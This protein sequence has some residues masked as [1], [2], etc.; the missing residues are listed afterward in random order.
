MISEKPEKNFSQFINKYS[1][2]KTLRFELRPIGNT[3]RMLI[4]SGVVEIDKQRKEA[5]I[6]TKPFFDK[7]HQEFITESL[8]GVKLLTLEG[9]FDLFDNWRK[10]KDKNEK[11]KTLEKLEKKEKEIRNEIVK[12]FDKKSADW[13]EN[14]PQDLKPKKINHEF[15]FEKGI[16][17]IAKEKYKEDDEILTEDG[18][19]IFD[20]WDKWGAYFGK[21]F[22]TRKNFYK[23]DGTATAVATRV[24]NDNLRRFCENLSLFERIVKIVNLSSIE[25]D[26]KIDL[27]EFFSFSQYNNILNQ[28]GI[29][30][31]NSLIGGET[32]E[33]GKKIKGINEL[34][35]EFRQKTKEKIPRLK[36]LDKQIGSER[37]IF[38]DTIESDEDLLTRLSEFVETAIEKNKILDESIDYLL[39]GEG[40][41]SKIYFRKEALNT[42]TRRWFVSYEKIAEALVLVI[43][44]KNVKFDKTK[45]EYK[46]PDFVNWQVIKEAVE[47]I[48]TNEE[49]VIWKSYYTENEQL[50]LNSKNHWQQFL[51]IFEF[52]YKNLKESGHEKDGESF[53]ELSLKLKEMLK[54]GKRE[55]E[56]IKRFS[57]R[58]LNLYRFAKYFSL[59]KSR[60]WN[61][62]GLETDDFYVKYEE[63]YSDSF[64][65]TVKTYDKIRNYMTKKPFNQEKWKLNFDNPTLADGWDKNKETD[66]TAVIL[67]KNGRYYLG[68]MEKKNN[69][70]FDKLESRQEEGGYEKMVYKLFPDPAK[71]MPKV[72]FSKK[73]IETF[74][75]SEEILRIYK[76]SE[77]KKGE[78]FSIDSM[79]KLIDFYKRALEKYEG[80]TLYD[81]KNVKNTNEYTENIGQFYRDVAEDGYFIVFENISEEYIE[82]ANQ[83]GKLYLFEI[84]NK[85]WNLKDGA[86]KTGT[87]NIHTLYFEQVFS[88]ENADNNF[89]IKLNGEA[90]LFFRSK[91]DKKDLGEKLIKGEKRINHFR[92]SKD[93]MFFHVPI[94]LNRTAPEAKK[95]NQ[96]I[97]EFL[98][99]NKNINIIGIDR[100]EKHLAY[101]SVINQKGE[102][103]EIK[104][105]NKITIRDDKNEVVREIDYASL[106]E[107]RAK[108]REQARK[109]WQSVEQIKDLKKGYIS[110]V[111]REVADLIIKYNAIVVFEDL[112]MRFKQV[113]GGIEKSVYQQLEKALIDKLNYLVSKEEIDSKKAGHILHAYQLT[114]K[115]DSFQKMGKQTGVLFYTQAEYTSQT[116]PV[117]GFRKNLYISNS[118]VIEK[119]K[120]FIKNFKAIGFD[121]ELQSYFF[122][123]NA[124]DFIVD[125][126]IKKTSYEKE[127]TVYA[128]VPRI[129]REKQASGHWETKIVNPNDEFKNLFEKWEFENI[130]AEDI[131]DLIFQMESDKRL[132]GTREFD[133]RKR[134]FWQSF[135]YLFNLV[136]Q[137]RN[138]T[139]TQFKKDEEGK[140]IEVVEGVDFIS[141]PVKPF[142]CT[143]A[144]KFTKG[145]TNMAG[146]ESKFIGDKDLKDKFVEEFNGD[147]NGAYNIARK[148]IIILNR[149]NEYYSLPEEKRPKYPDIFISRDDWDR[150]SQ[151]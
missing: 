19:T 4:D 100:G 81:F 116:D 9:Y 68:I 38:I 141:S 31:Y 114:E 118:S 24:V 1:L 20:S 102:I 46:F 94:T 22:E 14:L 44:D 17:A 88:K 86:K 99:N 139:S 96:S 8:S 128:D 29:T 75:P 5:Y 74:K 12:L 136:M 54:E 107:E 72:C 43:N 149:L 67:R 90:E 35:N 145:Y 138:S 137:V 61:P 40:D 25:N 55:T 143:D 97:N 73:G 45:E 7:L 131:K 58:V 135:I 89:I 146:M 47:K 66:N 6:K 108:N 11:K 57:D 53:E 95:F 49:E 134:N 121:K 70:L 51:V 80:W 64:E 109:D 112:N 69:R 48:K 120:S 33:D 36:K 15:L 83:D 124:T 18:R 101:L 3:E 26:F 37:E 23:D 115:F 142:F 147:A 126:K 77:F 10:A 110:H 39:S 130:E 84:H 113:R 122:I 63:F 13:I 105:L 16:F 78:T 21:F 119:I 140:V 111:V 79:Q 132:E 42:I 59:D 129:K 106:L 144:G 32:R 127:W 151:L 50:D 117:T 123:Y 85:D 98:A 41:L 92:Y 93:K 65:Q 52:E 104:S 28:E 150:F 56:T 2:S 125:S 133:G 27:D 60:R 30:F 148:G 62:D 34:V 103:L 76:N 71:M 91:T 87:K 82:K